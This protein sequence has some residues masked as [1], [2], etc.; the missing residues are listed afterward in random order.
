LSKVCVGG[1]KHSRAQQA[2]MLRPSAPTLV[3]LS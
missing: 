3:N 1:D 2:A